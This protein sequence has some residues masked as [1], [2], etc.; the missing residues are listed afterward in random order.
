LN[1]SYPFI[2]AKQSP[3]LVSRPSFPL[4][5]AGAIQLKDLP[6]DDTCVD[7]H[8]SVRAV[9]KLLQQHPDWLGVIL[10]AQD[11]FVGML[12]RS[13][14]SELLGRPLGF[15]FFSKETIFAYFEK[16]ASCSLVLDGSISVQQA[17]RA[18]LSRENDLIYDP[19]V[20]RLGEHH[21]GLLDTQALLQAPAD[22]LEKPSCEFRR[23]RPAT[24]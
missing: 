24:L 14:C 7:I 18:A 6:L 17:V 11:Q 5:A 20:V 2:D 15:E 4:F 10:T 8:L 21:Y 23:L 1:L 16:H 22:L 13:A 3:L 19:I 12:T 9:A